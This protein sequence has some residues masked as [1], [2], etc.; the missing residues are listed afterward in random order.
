[1]KIINIINPFHIC[2]QNRLFVKMTFELMVYAALIS[3][4]IRKMRQ[5]KLILEL[6][7]KS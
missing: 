3:A 4:K 2:H 1:M 5:K 7:N 6:I